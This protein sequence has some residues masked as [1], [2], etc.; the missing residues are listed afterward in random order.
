MNKKVMIIDDEQDARLLLR[1]YIAAYPFF[2]IVAESANGLEAVEAIDRLQP[3]IIFL[4]VN[5]PGLNGFQVVQQ[6]IHM[7]RII[8]TTAYDRYAL[9]AFEVN[10]VD[11]LLKPYT[12]DRFDKAIE[13]IEQ[14]PA[15]TEER[16][17]KLAGEYGGARYVTRVL[18]ESGYK[19]INIAVR[20]ILFIEAAKDYCRIHTDKK[21]YL[22][23]YGI[24]VLEQRLDP[25]HFLRIH[26][27][28]IVNVEHVKEYHKEGG[29]AQVIMDNGQALSVSRNY[30]EVVKKI[31]F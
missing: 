14:L 4:D 9:K 30:M 11:Y 16:I 25:L 13:K 29:T 22:S 6:I 5:M 7:P 1:E 26:R 28:W 3:E 27:S 8:F 31:I 21:N 19:Y 17:R 24:G 18:V 12:E 2:E 15:V 20:D 23:N 10:A